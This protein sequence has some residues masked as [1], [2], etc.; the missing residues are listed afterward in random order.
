MCDLNKIYCKTN[1]PTTLRNSWKGGN[2]WSPLCTSCKVLEDFCPGFF[3]IY[4]G[5]ESRW[6]QLCLSPMAHPRWYPPHRHLT[7][8][9]FIK[10]KTCRRCVPVECWFSRLPPGVQSN[11][12]SFVGSCGTKD[13]WTNHISTKSNCRKR[14]II[15]APAALSKLV[16]DRALLLCSVCSALQ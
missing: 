8:G 7:A 13:L 6:F 4:V 10:I 16:I 14:R 2:Q 11:C 1:K 3:F 5:I 12:F 15:F 9:L